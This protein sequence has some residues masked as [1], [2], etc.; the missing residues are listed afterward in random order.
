MQGIP[1]P[2]PTEKKKRAELSNMQCV[3]V[4][5]ECHQDDSFLLRLQDLRSL[6]EILLQIY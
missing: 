1:S 4:V 3:I 2:I 5:E 6:L